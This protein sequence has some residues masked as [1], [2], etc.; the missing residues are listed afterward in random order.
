MFLASI[1]Q[2]LDGPTVIRIGVLVLEVVHNFCG[3]SS[4]NIAVAGIN[5]GYWGNFGAVVTEKVLVTL[6]ADE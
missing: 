5:S 2:T 4:V 6:G 3:G 1:E